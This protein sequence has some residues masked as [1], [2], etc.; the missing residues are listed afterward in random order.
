MYLGQAPPDIFSGKPLIYLPT[1]HSYVLYSVGINGQDEDGR[2]GGD[3]PPGDDLSV[4]MQAPGLSE[5]V[6][7]G[8]CAGFVL[9]GTV[10]MVVRVC[11]RRGD[12][13]ASAVSIDIRQH[14]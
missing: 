3:E 7:W 9:L 14:R 8:A 1:R 2:G 4:H 12:E 11:W 5:G 13:T 6:L 10:F